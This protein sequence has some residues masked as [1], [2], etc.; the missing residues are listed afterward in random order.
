MTVER[1]EP[2]IDP[3]SRCD[4]PWWGVHAARYLFARRFAERRRILDVACGT[5]YGLPLLADGGRWVAG[6]DTDFDSLRTARAVAA[7][8]ATP[9]VRT[10]ACHQIGRAHV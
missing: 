3:A 5:G 6:A 8:V 9:L 2:A 4:S 10:D 1:H 7:N